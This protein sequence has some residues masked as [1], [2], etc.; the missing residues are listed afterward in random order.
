MEGGGGGGRCSTALSDTV[1]L[2]HARY[3][4]HFFRICERPYQAS[5]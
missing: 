4:E 3:Q 2:T 1:F 5:Q